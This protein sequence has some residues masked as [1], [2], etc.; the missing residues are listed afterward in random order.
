MTRF[1]VTSISNAF[2]DSPQMASW[3]QPIAKWNP[4]SATVQACRKVF[5]DP[6]VSPSDAWPMTHPV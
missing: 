3:V 5:G 4:F 1:L 2:V 6:N